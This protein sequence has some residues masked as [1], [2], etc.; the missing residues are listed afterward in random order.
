VDPDVHDHGPCHT[1][2]FRE[3]EPKCEPQRLTV[4]IGIAFAIGK[5][6]HVTESISNTNRRPDA[7]IHTDW[8]GWDGKVDQLDHGYVDGLN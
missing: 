7:P 6:V 2:R 5:P 8:P 3:P 4:T 1:G